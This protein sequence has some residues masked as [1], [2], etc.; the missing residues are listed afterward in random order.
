MDKPLITDLVVNDA[1]TPEE[2]T[3]D[4]DCTELRVLDPSALTSFNYR[5]PLSS[6]PAVLMQP[7]QALDFKASS[8]EAVFAKGRSFGFLETVTP[9]GTVTFKKIH[10]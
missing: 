4:V 10:K 9:G 2:I 3:A 5:A 6:S 8:L 7:G 1:A